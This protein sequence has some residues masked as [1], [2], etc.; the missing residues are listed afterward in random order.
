MKYNKRKLLLYRLRK[1]IPQMNEALFPHTRRNA[2]SVLTVN[3]WD[4]KIVT[5]FGR[6]Q[7]K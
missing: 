2:F 7:L 4:M 1:S 3:Y 5:V 6:R